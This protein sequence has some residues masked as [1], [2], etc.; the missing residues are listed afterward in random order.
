MARHGI[1]GMI[2]GTATEYVER[3]MHLY[4]EAQARHGRQL[5]LGENLGLG[6]WCY[7]DETHEKAKR[8]LQPM[9]E[10]HVK[11]AAPLGMLRYN[12]Q[13]MAAT[14]PGGVAR[15]I[16]AGANFEE[17]LEK[18]A[19]FCGTPA[20]TVAYLQ[21]I[22]ARYPGLEHILLGFPMGASLSQ[23]KEQLACFAHEVMPAFKKTAVRV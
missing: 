19:W 15:H 9:F 3:W 18:Q 1:K 7:M 6:L 22:E 20:E 12:D 4:Q 14:G 2:L 21:E 16:A 23:F 10:E 8:T 13:Q 5:Q 11:F 17:V